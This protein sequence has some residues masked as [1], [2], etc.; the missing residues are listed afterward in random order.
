[1]Q[2]A[3]GR[4]EG[5]VGDDAT[6]RAFKGI[7][8]ARPPVGELCWRLPQPPQRWDGTRP[9]VRD[10]PWSDLDYE[11]RRTASAQHTDRGEREDG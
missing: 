5:T 8:Y 11:R 3:E 9:A 6:V 10:W 2:V 1:M 7:P 4:L